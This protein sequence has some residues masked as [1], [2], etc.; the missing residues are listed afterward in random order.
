MRSRILLA[1]G[2]GEIVVFAVFVGC[3]RA[4][5]PV[6]SSKPPTSTASEI[7]RGAYITYSSRNRV[8][9]VGNSFF[10]R[11]LSVDPQTPGVTT[12]RLRT[13]DG[14]DLLR[15]STEE[16]RIRVGE[17][18]LLGFGN[19]LLYD[20]YETS[21]DPSGIRRVR[22]TLKS[23]KPPLRIALGFEVFPDVPLMRKSLEVVNLSGIPLR[24]GGVLVERLSLNAPTRVVGWERQDTLT[25]WDLPASAKDEGGL[26]WLQETNGALGFLNEAPGPLKR[27]EINANGDLLIGTNEIASEFWIQ[28]EETVVFPGVWTYFAEDGNTLKGSSTLL[29]TLLKFRR[30]LARE[31]N[32][33]LYVAEAHEVTP[34][35][36]ERLPPGSVVCL[37]YAWQNDL[38]TSSPPEMLFRAA[39]TIRNSGHP[40]GLRVPLSWLPSDWPTRQGTDWVQTDSHGNPIPA[41]WDSTPGVQA[42]LASDYAFVVSQSLTAIVQRLNPDYL[43]LDGTL[44]QG[45]P[46]AFGYGSKP[47]RPSSD[48]TL[49]MRTLGLLNLLTREHP[50]MALGVSSELYGMS[51]GFDMPLW[52]VGFLWS[53]S[54]HDPNDSSWRVA[55][56][57]Y[58]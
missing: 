17:K 43:L 30:T 15:G 40:L 20:S 39:T 23:P 38:D 2:I 28:N 33:P 22:I 51:R 35:A 32:S 41:M 45:E 36:L 5:V 9:T 25:P 48:W 37:N 31:K 27:A 12:I 21:G 14:K 44:R 29:T 50:R 24:I 7:L 8:I 6:R 53:W 58:P 34:T 49:W 46:T 4:S 19:D 26:F 1:I 42:S 54:P 10:S 52:N 57:I 13:R 18:D 3:G 56:S 16:F 11:T 47:R 55:Q